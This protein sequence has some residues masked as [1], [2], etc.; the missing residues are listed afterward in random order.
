MSR[1]TSIISTSGAGVPLE[2]RV[3]AAYLAAMLVEASGPGD[4]PAK[5]VE[6]ILFQRT[7]PAA[8]FDDLH[9]HHRLPTGETSSTWLQIKR[10]LT[11]DRSDVAFRRPVGDAARLLGGGDHDDA[12]FRIV[13]SQSGFEPRDVDRAKT[14][15]RSSSDSADFWGRWSASGASSPT[16]RAYTGAVAWVVEQEFGKANTDLAWRVIS[17]LGIA[18]LDVDQ[19]GSQAI[20]H[21]VDRLKL[22]LVSGEQGEAL[23]LFETLCSFASDVAGVAGGVDRPRLIAELAPRYRLKTAMSVHACLERIAADANAAL[24]SIRNDTGGVRLARVDLVDR[25]ASE[26]K[27]SRSLRLA[28]EPGA[29]KSVVLRAVAECQRNDG[30]GLIVLKHDRLTAVSW[31]AHASIL[32]VVTPLRRLVDELPVG[33]AGLLVLDGFD[34]IMEAGF[35]DLV[36]EI[37]DA[38]EK[39]PTAPLWRCL[40]SSRDSAGPEPSVD[41][42]LLTDMPR[43][44][45]GAPDLEDLAVLAERVPALGPLMVRHGFAGLNRN[46]FFLDQMARN[47]ADAGASSE[48]DL[49]HAWARRGASE[50]PRHP[51]R[52]S[53]LRSLGEQRLIQPY[54]PL[55]KVG[56]EDG[57]ARLASEQTVNFPTY[58]DVVT[59]SHDIY[60]EWAV[61]RALDARRAE[62]PA[63]LKAA[64]QPLVW[65]RA[66]RLVAEIAIEVDGP[67]GWQ[68][69]H[70]LLANDRDLDPLW[71]RLTLTAP[72]HSPRAA[73][74][75]DR[76]ER[77]LLADQAR[78]MDDLIET[79]LSLEVQPHPVVLSSPDFAHLTPTERRRVAQELALPRL[80]P[81]YAFL[82]W[83]ADRWSVWPKK[84]VPKLASATLTWLRGQPHGVEPTKKIVTQCVT[85]LRELDMIWSLS[86]HDWEERSRR[87]A[88]FGGESSRRI[89]P[90]R[91][92]LRTVVATGAADAVVEVDAYLA[93]L[94]ASDPGDRTQ[95]LETPGVLPTVLPERFVDLVIA[96][97]VMRHDPAEPLDYSLE[98]CN[99]IRDLGRF[100]PASPTR[101]GCD[102]LFAADEDQALRLLDALSAAA[103]AVWRRREERR[104]LTP[105]PL[106]LA[107]G[108]VE[109]QLWGD[110]HV[111]M[112]ACGLLG[113][114]LLGSLFLATDQWMAT[115]IA[116]GR[117]VAE[118]CA[119]VLGSSHLVASASL[120]LLAAKDGASSVE[121]LCSVL[122]L[123]I[124]PRLW[125]YD[126]RLTLE[127]RRGT[128]FQIGWRPG[129]EHA[130][131]AAAAVRE[132]RVRHL[133]TIDGLIA[134]LHL[135]GDAPLK[136]AFAAAVAR[137]DVGDLAA[138]DEE[139]EDP[140]ARAELDDELNNWRAR[141]DPENWQFEKGPEKGTIRIGYAAPA[142]LSERAT[143]VL[144]RQAALEESGK[145]IDWAFGHAKSGTTRSGQ[146]FLEALPIAKEMDERDL[147]DR[148]LDFDPA[149]V[150][151]SQG[152]AAVAAAVTTY[153]ERDLVEGER[154]WLLSVFLRAASVDHQS[155]PIFSEET[156]LS[157]D[158]AASAARGL[159]ALVMRGLADRQLTCIWLGLVGSPFRDIAKAALESAAEFATA[160]PVLCA[161]ALSVCADSMLYTWH[162]LRQD[163]E[164]QMKA[165]RA[166]R[167]QRAIDRAL[168]TIDRGEISIPAFPK[169]V[170]K[171][172]V[173]GD[174]SNP[175]AGDRQAQFDTYRASD[176][177]KA[178][179]VEAVCAVP[180]IREGL[181]AYISDA[182]QWYASFME[183]QDNRRSCGSA[184]RHMDWEST[185]GGIAGRL[186]HL[187]PAE[188]TIAKLVRPAAAIPEGEARS[189][190]LAHLLNTFADTMVAR[191]RPVDASFT[192]VWRAASEPLFEHARR[193]GSRRYD[194]DPTPLAAAAFAH[195]SLPVFPPNWPRASELAD[196]VHE[197]IVNCA[198]YRFSA[199]IVR[200]L[201]AQAG[202][203]FVPKPGLEWL[204]MI[205]DAHDTLD[206]E[207]RSVI[208]GAAGEILLLLW[209]GSD[210]A[211]R[212]A[213][214]V[215][216]R[217]AAA[218]LADRGVSLAAELLPEIAIVQASG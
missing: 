37:L 131:R 26:L 34:R 143:E 113:P 132:R 62:M 44:I 47:P 185:M 60:E 191:D 70:D 4:D 100:F 195:Y 38:I 108:G 78:L 181:I 119:K 41:A 211:A 65:M 164:E 184:T 162:P 96:K 14:F 88:E 158:P 150:I 49:M 94:M 110:Q 5:A 194:P 17:R 16:E 167:R 57:L 209:S 159:G 39:S 112:W 76:L 198:R 61:A 200:R 133:A 199:S 30:A 189:D 103:A 136:E 125:H 203:A 120:C 115:Q 29:G 139:I 67:E 129:D 134:A 210:G 56:E 27:L 69:F 206:A 205:L 68:A 149:F 93:D 117:P 58:R 207:E 161:A 201:I 142:P 217:S 33:G 176:I 13:A 156:P 21:A 179:D 213:N 35:G 166:E 214:I 19:V 54:K 92:M 204:A 99:G 2:A 193:N 23:H 144:D 48:L 36:R 86:F 22:A 6:H 197:W 202:S 85:W 216:F 171:R 141:A 126:L 8:G 173:A 165:S 140:S 168:D 147:F 155:S 128:A 182:L 81:W 95:F 174:A 82:V 170:T 28:G 218:R 80:V 50:T 153:G 192:A 40:M 18:V 72:L 53:T 11:G 121:A 124:Q 10:T 123:L 175:C 107:I 118:V 146:T 188:D 42:P 20:A 160:N 32:G 52:D 74:A 157:E 183:F 87:L 64:G 89:D 135:L 31:V 178:V 7:D 169:P 215:R 116:A 172:F 212:R 75:L 59:F 127:D 109:R 180:A 83:S 63:I 177:W 102:Q 43:L 186:A 145:L 208:G 73:R 12:N 138:F 130:Y 97:M 105:R 114:H 55:P 90:V 163:F 187:L 91:D 104:G 3:A 9:L 46:L 151:R 1:A 154:D 111:F 137:W 79:L 24:A 148:L 15:A 101:A 196:L 45:V 106:T 190:V 66:V 71:R 25:A 51:S 98:R 152:V 77:I 84:L 122:P